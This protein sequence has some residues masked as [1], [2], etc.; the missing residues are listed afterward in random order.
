MPPD[1]GMSYSQNFRQ[2]GEYSPLYPEQHIPAPMALQNPHPTF[3]APPPQNY[4]E[5]FGVQPHINPRFASAF[6]LSMYPPPN[7][8]PQSYA[9]AP[10]PHGFPQGQYGTPSNWTD[11]RSA[12]DGSAGFPFND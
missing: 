4:L 7:S 5:P 12:Q 6:G 10:S 2:D 1:Q 11:E 8:T 3:Y 9:S